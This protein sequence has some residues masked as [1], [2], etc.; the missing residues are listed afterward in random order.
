MSP[1][2]DKGHLPGAINHYVGNGSLDLA[3][4]DLDKDKTYLVYCHVN[5]AAI[6]GAE[7][8]SK[9]GFGQVYR[10]EGNYAGWVEDD[11]PIEVGLE[12][13][14]DFESSGVATRSFLNNQF[15]HTVAA[16]LDDPAEGKFYEGWLVR[17]E[18]KLEFF[19][20]GKLELQN[21]AYQLVY[22]DETSQHDYSQVV[23]TQ[24]TE[25]NGLDNVPETHV[26]E[27]S[28]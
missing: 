21:G 8:L 20:T 9:A 27:G 11:Y 23:I 4:P 25:A 10:L 16:S 28:F 19:S 1:N 24:E 2:Y 26:L 3:I 6:L 15:E 17:S 18:P 7:K 14:G 22:T 12:A 5:S 13:V